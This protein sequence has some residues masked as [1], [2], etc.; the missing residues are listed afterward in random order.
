[1]KPKLVKLGRV[2]ICQGDG[3]VGCG[4]TGAKAYEQWDAVRQYRRE[5]EIRILLNEARLAHLNGQP[6]GGRE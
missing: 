5:N 6:F 3:M 4:L 2:W 1:M